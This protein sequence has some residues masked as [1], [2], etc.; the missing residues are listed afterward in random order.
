MTISYGA[1]SKPAPCGVTYV[2]NPW[3]VT[4]TSWILVADLVSLRN[5]FNTIAPSR[6]KKSDGSI[7]DAA[8]QAESSDHNPDETGA[9]PYE[10]SDSINEVHAIDVDNNLN[11]VFPGYSDP[12]EG[13]V[14]TIVGRHKRGE[15]NRLQNI[16]YKRRIWSRSWGWTEH[17]YNGASPH[18]EHAHFSSRY[19]SGSGTS[20]PENIV[21][22]WG[23]IEAM[24]DDVI[25]KDDITAIAEK[26]WAAHWGTEDAGTKLVN[27]DTRIDRI[28]AK[29]D[30]LLTAVGVTPTP[31]TKK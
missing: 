22:P 12:M 9:T 16:I 3:E 27:I 21:K 7:G 30:Q 13:C 5:E 26:V 23:L 18:D 17:E 20:N 31:D 11:I 29:V 28:E 24:E 8:H 19:G 6:D 2:F 10:D 15:D 14:Q 1:G 4:L 25:T